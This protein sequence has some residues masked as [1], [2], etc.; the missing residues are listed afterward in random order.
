MK[1]R[2]SVGIFSC[3]LALAAAAGCDEDTTPRPTTGE[4][5]G[6]VEVNDAAAAEEDAGSGIA[7][8]GAVEEGDGGDGMTWGCVWGE[9]VRQME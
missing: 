8:A 1:S 7:D 9:C 2:D 6:E 5:G 3:V 4:T